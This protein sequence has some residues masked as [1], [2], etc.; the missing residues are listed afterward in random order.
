MKTRTFERLALAVLAVLVLA[1][2]IVPVRADKSVTALLTRAT[3]TGPGTAIVSSSADA[4]GAAYTFQ[5]SHLDG[6]GVVNIETTVDGETWSIVGSLRQKGDIVTR[7]A[8]GNCAFRGNIAQ[9]N[10]CVASVVATFSGTGSVA[11]LTPTATPTATPTTTPT[12]TST[13]TPTH[14]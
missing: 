5:L 11:V 14:S 4:A 12:A 6:D 1:V 2:F 7:P 8:C 10:S 9:C 13:P 3:T